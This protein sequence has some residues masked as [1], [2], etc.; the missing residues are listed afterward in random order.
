MKKTVLASYVGSLSSLGVAT[1]CILPMALML[2]GLGGSWIAIFGKIAA[3]SFH[4]L[5]I[6]STL[7]LLA[8]FF[9]F[10]GRS[11]DRLKWWLGG[12]TVLTLAAWVIV[13]NETRINDYLITLM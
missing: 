6:S 1:C 5:G 4:V 11:S 8:W 10:R 12:S 2:V 9:S 13:F 3:A 7:L